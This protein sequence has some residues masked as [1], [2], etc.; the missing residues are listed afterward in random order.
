MGDLRLTKN[1]KVVLKKIIEQARVSD[2]EISKDMAISQQAVQKIRTKL[3]KAGIIK[4]Y[5]PLIDFQKIGIEVLYFTGLEVLPMMWKKF[6]EAEINKKILELPFLFELFRVPTAD[7]SYIVIFGFKSIYEKEMF[8]K[9]LEAELSNELKII[10]AYTASVNNILAQDGL[11]L[12]LHALTDSAKVNE[13]I[14]K[15]KQ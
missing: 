3:E 4:G 6:S 9:K 14:R 15:M 12:V 5:I 13:S 7:I 2:T 8:S 1:D 10:W 11:N